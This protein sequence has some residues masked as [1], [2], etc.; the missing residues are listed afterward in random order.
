MADRGAGERGVAVTA[1]APLY[2]L[3]G[4]R[5]WVAGHRG[6]VGRALVRRLSREPVELLTVPRA[7]LD[8]TEGAAVRAW[9][10]RHRP[11]VVILAAAKV[12]GILANATFP[13][14]FLEENLR[15]ELEVITAS[16]EL[17]VEKLLFLGSSCIYPRDC[18][19]PIREEHLLTGPLE[20]TNR[21]YALAKI[22]GLELCRAYRRE[23]GRDFIACMPTNLYG[24]HDDFDPETGHVLAALLRRFHEAKI[25][26]DREVVVWGTGTP[27]REFLH[28]EDLA[29]ACL[30]LLRH[31]SDDIPI[32]IGCGEDLTIAELADLLART[33]G[34]RGTIR[35]D[36]ARP[37]GTPRKRLDVSRI[38]ALGWRPEIPLEQGVR[39]TYR[40]FLA[41][42]AGRAVGGAEQMP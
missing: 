1:A 21:S 5:V 25:R 30:H 3:A 20:A 8:L 23:R 7:E 40:W 41:H 16:A 38:T 14:A 22:C 35:F 29:A 10:A 18:R 32:N 12:G 19:Q 39:R 4:K 13:V 26:G 37:D 2:D 15:I 34:F 17:G 42:H 31:F 11:D 27:R 36:P 28:V 24:P 6:M 9:I 33:T